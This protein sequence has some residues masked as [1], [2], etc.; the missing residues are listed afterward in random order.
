MT[1]KA[2]RY[3]ETP[4]EKWNTRHF[5]QYLEAEH[6]RHYG[7]IYTPKIG[8]QAEAGLLAQYIGTGPQSKRPKQRKVTNVVLK[9]FIDRCFA[10]YT[11]NEKYAGVAFV[12]MHEYM[13]E[14]LQKADAEFKRKQSEMVAKEIEKASIDEDLAWL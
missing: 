12:F 3:D 7:T 1:A 5:K 4:V 8:H 10:N 14:H 6:L 11:P 9:D 13:G 2:K